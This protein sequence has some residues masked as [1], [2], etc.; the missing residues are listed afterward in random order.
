MSMKTSAWQDLQSVLAGSFSARASGVVRSRLLLMDHD[1]EEFGRL[2]VHG[3]HG[4]R[5]KA[6]P[7]EAEIELVGKAGE[8]S[9]RMLSGEDEILSAKATPAEM[10]SVTCEG[11]THE[12]R[13]SLF[14]NYAEAA[15]PRGRTARI[16]GGFLNRRYEVTLGYDEYA[17][18]VA[19]FLL[20]HLF[21]MRSRAYRTN[22]QPERESR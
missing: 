6:G 10:T 22:L 12:V 16:E 13:M 19:V 18:P 11:V 15:S 14:R 1:G 4:G 2:D 7:V 21:V 9:Y 3:P 17:L 8:A 20:Y 5:L